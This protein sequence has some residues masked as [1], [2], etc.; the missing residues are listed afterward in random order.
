MSAEVRVLVLEAI[1][2]WSLVA[3]LSD[4]PSSVVPV[5]AL[6]VPCGVRS[7]T[8]VPGI[9]SFFAALSTAD[10]SAAG[11]MVLSAEGVGAWALATAD[12]AEASAAAVKPVPEGRTPPTTSTAAHAPTSAV[13][14]TVRDT[15]E[16]A[17]AGRAGLGASESARVELIPASHPSC[18]AVPDPAPGRLHGHF[19]RFRHIREVER[20]E[21]ITDEASRSC[22]VRPGSP[23]CCGRRR[24][25][26]SPAPPRR[27][28]RRP[29]PPGH[30]R[31][32]RRPVR[33]R[34]PAAG[35]RPVEAAGRRGFRGRNGSRP[36]TASRRRRL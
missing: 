32:V 28:R 22:R 29:H 23:S 8:T 26:V 35:R 10:W 24:R 7:R 34:P 27:R 31:P 15:P 5:V 3:G 25:R 21:A 2:K 4:F 19:R 17:L 14:R 16:P 30:P 33:T 13:R 20:W 12:A 18:S 1:R 6:N 11:S 9:M 36:C